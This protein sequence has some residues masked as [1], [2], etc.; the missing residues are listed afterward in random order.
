MRIHFAK[1]LEGFEALKDCVRQGSLEFVKNDYWG[2]HYRRAVLGHADK[3]FMRSLEDNLEKA[4]SKKGHKI[5]RNAQKGFFCSSPDQFSVVFDPTRVEINRVKTNEK[6]P[7]SIWFGLR[8]RIL[9]VYDEFPCLDITGRVNYMAE[10][11]PTSVLEALNELGY[12]T[13]VRSTEQV[14]KEEL[15]DLRN[16]IMAE[17]ATAARNSV[18]RNPYPGCDFL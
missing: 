15:Q 9:P 7:V 5:V 17:A 12:A 13:E 18:S 14:K 2:H 10:A 4:L 16:Q 6:K 8:T 11:D 1:K 3:N